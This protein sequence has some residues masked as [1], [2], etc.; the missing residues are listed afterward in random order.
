MC[1]TVLAVVVPSVLW[2]L[3]AMMDVG[4]WVQPDSVA[5]LALGEHL[6][7]GGGFEH[8]WFVARTPGYPMLLA[9]AAVVGGAGSSTMV[10]MMQHGMVV[11]C[12]VIMTA[13]GW[14]LSQSRTTGLVCGLLTGCSWA[15]TGYAGTVLTEAP[16]FFTLM[17]SLYG[18]CRFVEAGATRWLA[19][20]S[21]GL[22]CAA[23][24]RPAA[25]PLA[26]LPVAALFLCKHRKATSAALSFR[27]RWF[28]RCGALLAAAGPFALLT[29]GWSVIT[30]FQ[31][32]VAGAGNFA[33]RT[34]YHRV[35]TRGGWT[36]QDNEA[37]ADIRRCVSEVN[38]TDANAPPFDARMEEHAVICL[39]RVHGFT[40][41]EASNRLGQAVAPIFRL[42]V[43][44]ILADTPRQ[45]AYLLLVP[46]EIHRFRP[47]AESHRLG[48]VGGA[49]DGTSAT[50]SWPST[51][52]FAEDVRR[53]LTEA[54][55]EWMPEPS[56]QA[57]WI[58]PLRSAAADVYDRFI[59][60]ADPCPPLPG[61]TVFEN[62]VC[63]CLLGSLV[64]LAGARRRIWAITLALVLLQV[65]PCA[66]AP[67]FDRR[68]SAPV[69]PVMH[70]WG[71][72]LVVVVGHFMVTRLRLLWTRH[73]LR[74][75]APS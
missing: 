44:E 10:L 42:H 23:L 69:R 32:G 50:A 45:A 18:L 67:G 71:V 66:F 24:I 31:H 61:D 53:R 4:L 25:M 33:G 14:R 27:R 68:F 48:R 41:A 20:G 59:L 3:S 49:E 29:G 22:G 1:P 39:Q 75:S 34:L 36:G 30:A 9:I 12:A 35:V 73:P 7:N 17:A 62:W 8:P 37:M 52:A 74:I 38:A 56:R 21:T 40:L 58:S 46:D 70:V 55:G 5:Y 54:G 72:Q 26:L 16:Y 6:R 51:A 15:L 43:W 63:V 47:E 13:L 65:L 64:V 28:A 11:G 57:S 19:L 60:R 2:Q